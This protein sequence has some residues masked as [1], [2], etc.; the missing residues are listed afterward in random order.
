M[1]PV[2]SDP[3]RLETMLGG[4]I[5]RFSRSLPSGTTV[6]VRLQPAGSRLK[7][8]LSSDEPG[9]GRDPDGGKS[10]GRGSTATVGPVL[11]WDPLTGSLQLSRQATQ[12]LFRSLGGRLTE[13]SGSGLTVFFP[14]AN[15]APATPS[16]REPA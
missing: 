16:P 4:L 10:W 9:G 6:W 12:D 14:L 3:S 11:R 5:D 7:L 1:P 13:R 8:Q 2:L 15:Q